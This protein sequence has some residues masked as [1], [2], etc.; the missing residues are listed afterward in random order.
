MS[1]QRSGTVSCKSEC[2][3]RGSSVALYEHLLCS[4]FFPS[5]PSSPSLDGEQVCSMT[6]RC[7]LPAFSMISI[8]VYIHV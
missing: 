3:G 5:R 4:S 1:L 8:L 7:M 2:V 6:I